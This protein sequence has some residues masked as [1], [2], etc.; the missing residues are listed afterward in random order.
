M[1]LHYIFD[2]LMVLSFG[3]IK[4]IRPDEIRWLIDHS[5]ILNTMFSLS[6]LAALLLAA[7]LFA[8]HY[9]KARKTREVSSSRTAGRGLSE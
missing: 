8:W 7:I 9:W 3:K 4:N 1:V 5:G 6:V 2:A